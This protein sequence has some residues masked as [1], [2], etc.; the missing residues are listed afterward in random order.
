M[1]DV[2]LD[3][4]DGSICVRVKSSEDE[5]RAGAAG[6]KAGAGILPA[7]VA[8]VAGVGAFVAI[9]VSDSDP[10]SLGAF[11]AIAVSDSDPVSH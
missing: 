6:A 10:V 11:V 9:A 7:I 3:A 5:R 2:S 1:R 8:G 4:A